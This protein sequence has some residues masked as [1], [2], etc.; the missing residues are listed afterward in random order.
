MENRASQT[1]IRLLPEDRLLPASHT[2]TLLEVLLQNGV[3][4][5]HS[6]C[7]MGSC[8]TCRILVEAGLTLLGGRGA[9]EAEIAGEYGYAEFERLACQNP[10]LPGLSIRLPLRKGEKP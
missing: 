2:K 3:E 7:G 9:V 1:S 4:I 6:C 8:G 5:S 10:A